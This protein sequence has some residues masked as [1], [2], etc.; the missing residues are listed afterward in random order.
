MNGVGRKAREGCVV[1]NMQCVDDMKSIRGVMDDPKCL[2]LQVDVSGGSWA[3]CDAPV[4]VD[5]RYV[6]TGDLIESGV[7]VGGAVEPPPV[8][9]VALAI[10]DVAVGLALPWSDDG[11][12]SD[13]DVDMGSSPLGARGGRR[14]GGSGG[15]AL[16]L[17]WSLCCFSRL[18]RWWQWW[19]AVIVDRGLSPTVW[20]GATR[21]SVMMTVVS[22][23]V[24]KTLL[25]EE[26]AG[27][28]GANAPVRWS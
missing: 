9:Q 19:L 10:R 23:P 3:P 15:G 1:P 27:L 28:A 2:W 7:A 12:D 22:T 17:W 18:S 4:M 21:W 13:S 24:L 16:V 26:A 8:P 14:L 25:L 6:V 11:S 20:M 5:D